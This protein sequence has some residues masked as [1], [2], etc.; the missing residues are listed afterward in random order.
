MTN[1]LRHFGEVWFV[2]FEFRA[3]DGERPTPLCMV[4]REFRS[5]RTVRV[6][7]D[8]LETM[9]RSPF[10]ITAD[11]LFLAYYAAA[12]L[13][14]FRA[15][16]WPMPARVL[17]LFAEF[18]CLTN[19]LE[20]ICGNGLLGALT[21]FGLDSIDAAE[22]AEMRNLAIRGGPYTEEEKT[23]LLDYCESDVVALARLLPKMLPQIDLPRALLRGRYMAAVSRIEWNG[24]PID[25]QTLAAL[26]ASWNVLQTKLVERVDVDFNCYDGTTF[27]RDRF[28]EWLMRNEIPWPRL[29]SGALALD[30]D[31]F[32]QMS[33]SYP[34]VAPLR[35]LRH[36]LGELRLESLAVGS[37]GRNRCLLSPFRSITGRNQPS[38]SRFIFGPSCWLRSL[39]KPPPN[40]AIAYVDWSQQEFGIA[41][42]LSRDQAMRDA[43]SSGDPYLTFAKQA[44]AIPAD[45]TKHSHPTEREL[46][47]VCALAV[48]YGM[49]ESTLAIKLGQPPAMARE[50][51]K[52]HRLTYPVYWQWSQA[53]VD[54]AMLLGW[55]GTVFGWRVHVGSRVNPRSLANFP[56]QANGAEMLRLA[57]CLAIERDIKVCAPVHDALLVEGPAD[58]IG[59]VV[60]QTQEAMAEASRIALEGFELRS[61]AKIVRYPD[62]YMDPR[63][64]K[65]WNT[66]M[67]LMPEL[68]QDEEISRIGEPSDQR[69]AL[70]RGDPPHRC[71]RTCRILRDLSYLI[72]MSY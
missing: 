26:R 14:C 51:L 8:E 52:L 35:E 23:A 36:S 9:S 47:K 71:G 2:D 67:S 25:V 50:L 56:M 12:E 63:G 42:A 31:T 66:I 69:P 6:W 17:D 44:G 13:G 33:R 37:D 15:L 20:T 4:T 28:A 46:F 21:Y 39:I 70:V 57:C 38:N 62:R 68:K 11:S 64:G 19:G 3:P 43:Y 60:R 72:Y 49:G 30:D 32:R 41:A 59:T 22:K 27:K 53:A 16:G 10:P 29:P 5:G 65:M 18:R 45:A 55:L 61:D 7:A 48:Q 58:D 40:T 1:L 54:H 34:A 24:A